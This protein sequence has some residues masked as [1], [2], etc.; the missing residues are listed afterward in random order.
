MIDMTN[1]IARDGLVFFP[2]FCSVCLKK[3]RED[4]EEQFA[5]IVFKVCKEAVSVDRLKWSGHF[6]LCVAL[7]HSQ[8]ISEQRSTK[9]IRRCFAKM[10]SSSS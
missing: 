9:S 6:R 3:L 8:S 4:D 5:Q 1:A 7:S 2:E 10:S